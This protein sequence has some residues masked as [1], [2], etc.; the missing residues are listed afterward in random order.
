[1]DG[2]FGHHGDAGSVK[3]EANKVANL[4]KSISKKGSLR[5]QV[6]LYKLLLKDSLLD[7]IDPA[8]EKITTSNVSID[9]HLHE[10]ARF[11]AFESPDRGPVKF[12]IALLGLIQDQQD[13][14]K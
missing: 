5:N 2:A 1:M 6:E 10:F 4:V 8:L 9:P 14:E 11:L 7:F 12:G 13:L 3:K